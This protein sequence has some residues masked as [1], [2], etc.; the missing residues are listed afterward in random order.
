MI[1]NTLDKENV[2]DEPVL[3]KPAR[4]LMGLPSIETIGIR[5][6]PS[7]MYKAIQRSCE[8]SYQLYQRLLQENK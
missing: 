5:I 7:E 1:E 6:S 3:P 8:R 2:L 4:K